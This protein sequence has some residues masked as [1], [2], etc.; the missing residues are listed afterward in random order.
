MAK[1]NELFIEL[2]ARGPLWLAIIILSITSSIGIAW[3]FQ[4]LIPVLPFWPAFIF[5]LPFV[6]AIITRF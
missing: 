6:A 3:I 5:A 2:S 4:A 1:R